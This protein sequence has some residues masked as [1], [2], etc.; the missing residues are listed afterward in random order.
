[1]EPIEKDPELSRL[2]ERYGTLELEP[3]EDAF[4]RLATSVI[5]QQ[6]ST[7]SA[8][9][10]RRRVFKKVEMTPEGVLEA[11]QEVLREVGLSSQKIDYLKRIA[12]EFR[13]GNI[14]RESLAELSDEEVVERLTSIRGIGVWT[15]K[16]FLMFVLARK[17]VFPVEDLGIR[18]GMEQVYGLDSRSEMLERA[19]EWRPYRS[20]AALYLWKLN[21]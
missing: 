9:A 21:D 18:R 8:E 4:R 17:D 1:M 5:N 12:A 11:D 10:I 16:M 19:E 7:S 6:L 15:A 2:V 3:A 14:G 13:S 20:I